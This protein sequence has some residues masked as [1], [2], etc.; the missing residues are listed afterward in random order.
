[1]QL[2]TNQEILSSGWAMKLPAKLLITFK[3]IEDKL[4][5]IDVCIWTL[6]IS[7]VK[8]DWWLIVVNKFEV[9]WSQ[10]ISMRK[11]PTATQTI[12]KTSRYSCTTQGTNW[13]LLKSNLKVM[14]KRRKS[15]TFKLWSFVFPNL[16]GLHDWFNIS[17]VHLGRFYVG[18]WVWQTC[19]FEQQTLVFS[20]YKYTLQ[21]KNMDKPNPMYLFTASSELHTA[22]FW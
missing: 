6:R 16:K 7:K 20:I 14:S 17:L 8:D 5:G 22:I 21:H 4:P 2:W 1:L 15:W 3:L 10:N 9:W 12:S 19:L 13:S 11:H 18:S